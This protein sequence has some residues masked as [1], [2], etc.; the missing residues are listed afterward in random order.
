MKK[1]CY[2]KLLFSFPVF[3]LLFLC[4]SYS[5]N[6]T[7]F[8]FSATYK[9]SNE[10]PA[11]A[12]TATGTISGTYNDSSNTI[13]YTITFSGLGSNTSAAHFH[14]PA[15]PGTNAAVVYA[16]AGF[17]IGVTSG[18][19]AV[20]TQVITDDQE[21]DLLAGKWY[22]NIHTDN[23]Q[24]GEIR[25]LIFFG[26]PF[27]APTITCPNDTIV[28]N[29]ANQCSQSVSFAADT[30]GS[31]APEITYKIGPTV[32]TSPFDFPAGTSTVTALALNGGG[33]ATCTFNVTVKDTQPPVITC[34]ANISAFNDPGVCG[35]NVRF[36]PTATD[37][38]PGILITSQPASGSLFP[39]GTST[40]TSTAT[41]AAGNTASC[42]FTVTVVDNEP[43][44]ISDLAATPDKLWPPDH[45]MKEVTVNYTSKDNCG[46]E[47]CELSV[48]SNE[49]TNGKGD[50]NT[51]PDWQVVD[52]HHV[53]LRAE[54]SGNGDGRIYTITVTCTDQYGNSASTSTT[55]KVPHDMSSVL[56]SGKM[57]INISPNPSADNF[58]LNI[59]T[60]NGTEKINMKII[61]QS[62]R[63]VE[64]RNNLTG[65]QLLRVGSNL[66]SGIYFVELQQGNETQQL[67]LLKLR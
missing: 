39:V 18:T 51:S 3:I 61:D 14:G 49:P 64:S 13:S 44:V 7:E 19:L 16:H 50:G 48:S 56:R 24:G 41:D 55:V 59:Q 52:E 54:R 2:Q 22:S 57:K 30:T 43:P 65:N 29:A 5:V 34:P 25:A 4:L 28:F 63:I 26:A 67:K 32:I 40:V 46:I 66:K 12:S 11:N 20:T 38:C 31:P 17:P 36:T 27:V 23:F 58:I 33:Y 15:I 9:G 35:A 53:W 42:S 1:L 62:G 10:V 60:I 21:K 6:A 47:S 8:P 37:N 45:K